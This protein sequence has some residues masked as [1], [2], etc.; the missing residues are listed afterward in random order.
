M[1]YY[2]QTEGNALEKKSKGKAK[3]QCN[4]LK[5]KEE[6]VSLNVC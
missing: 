2:K 3:K 5:W 1:T 4:I 6:S